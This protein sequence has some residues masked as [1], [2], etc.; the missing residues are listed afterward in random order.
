MYSLFSRCPQDLAEK[1]RQKSEMLRGFNETVPR[2]E[3][4]EER[5]K[6]S[7]D[8]SLRLQARL[9][10]NAAEYLKEKEA[11]TAARDA[12]EQDNTTLLAQKNELLEKNKKLCQKETGEYSLIL[13]SPRVPCICNLAC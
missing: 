11:L 4:L 5:L 7:E 1:S 6:K 9:D 2:F 10:G 3:K 8:L 12:L 13:R